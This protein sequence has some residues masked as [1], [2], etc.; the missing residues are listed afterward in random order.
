WPLLVVAR[1]PEAPQLPVDFLGRFHRS[2]LAAAAM[3]GPN[4]SHRHAARCLG[5][6]AEHPAPV[7]SRCSRL[8]CP[9]V[10]RS[11][12][13]SSTSARTAARSASIAA[14]SSSHTLVCHL[15][16]CPGCAHCMP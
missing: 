5:H 15:A 7:S 8:W 10:Q 6:P 3:A 2:P 1:L 16:V 12:L 4:A 9:H 13:A 14:V 11:L